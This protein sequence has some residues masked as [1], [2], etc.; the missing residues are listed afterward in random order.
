MLHKRKPLYT[1][2]GG[3]KNEVATLIRDAKTSAAGSTQAV[4]IWPRK[5]RK[6]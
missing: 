2:G 6:L 4:N 1:H 3:R 5:K